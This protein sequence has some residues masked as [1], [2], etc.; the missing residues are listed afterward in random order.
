MGNAFVEGVTSVLSG[1]TEWFTSVFSKIGG[2]LYTEPATAGGTGSLT[3]IGW[4]IT[5]VVGL[6]VVGFVISFVMKLVSK[7]KAK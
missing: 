5:I 6:G 2:I 7:I 4:I 1:I 3:V